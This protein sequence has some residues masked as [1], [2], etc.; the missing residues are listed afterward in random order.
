M[1]IESV[2]IFYTFVF[3]E[4]IKESGEPEVNLMKVIHMD[5]F[6]FFTWTKWGCMVFNWG[7]LHMVFDGET[8]TALAAQST[9][10]GM[11]PSF[12]HF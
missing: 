2:S 3:R 9:V 10:N 5:R 6:N 7:G 1:K 8:I 11:N 4:D 12:Y